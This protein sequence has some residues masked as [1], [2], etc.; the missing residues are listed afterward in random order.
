[1]AE[2]TSAENGNGRKS[3]TFSV[4]VSRSDFTCVANAALRDERLSYKAKGILAACL[5]H[6][7]DFEFT[8]AWIESHG[9]EGRDAIRAG[10]R[11]LR[12]LGYL[13]NVK[14]RNSAGQISGER[15]RFSDVPSLEQAPGVS[16]ENQRP[17]NQ[18][19]ENQRTEKPAAGFSGRIRIPIEENQ[20]N[21]P[22]PPL[23]AKNPSTRAARELE[24]LSNL[25]MPPWLEP[26]REQILEWQQRRREKHKRTRYEISRL[27]IKA[28]EYAR[29]LNCLD[30][31]LE[32]V[33][34]KPWL[35]LGHLGYKEFIEGVAGMRPNRNQFNASN[36]PLTV[37]YTLGE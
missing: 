35:S 30:A 9:T 15:Y 28:L 20:E 17:E 21:P 7:P 23:P 11:E 25:E 22:L 14:N 18:R 37:N 33:S 13:T 31:Y 1:M 12:D 36:Q 2:N 19:P 5:S 26:Y 24:S 32:I 29:E 16:A 27:S 34:E 3:V 4:S 8:R 10:L 6:N